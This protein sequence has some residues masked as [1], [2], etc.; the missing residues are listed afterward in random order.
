MWEYLPKTWNGKEAAA[1]YEGAIAKTLKKARGEKRKYL[2]LE[3]NDPTGYKS[4]V[5]R[6][7]KVTILRHSLV[8]RPRRGG[9]QLLQKRV[10]AWV[11]TSNRCFFARIVAN[12]VA[13]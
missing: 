12:L 9:F 5:A 13:N 10:R 2:V 7:K 3:D 8:Y 1:F 11:P 6:K 4:N